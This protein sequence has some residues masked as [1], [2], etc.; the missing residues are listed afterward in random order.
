MKPG[1]K[2]IRIVKDNSPYCKV[3]DI[4]TVIDHND[5]TVIKKLG[6]IEGVRSL[7]AKD[8]IAIDFGNGPTYN[9]ERY[10]EVIPPER[11]ARGNK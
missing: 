8:A 10:L 5:E 2:V 6:D 3:G 1:D 4:G 11:L 9:L 7:G